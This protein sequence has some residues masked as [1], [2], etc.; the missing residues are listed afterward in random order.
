MAVKK[1]SRQG[2]PTQNG[3]RAE[4]KS[5][6]PEPVEKDGLETG[7][8]RRGCGAG[9]RAGRG[10]LYG[11]ISGRPDDCGG[12]RADG[13]GCPTAAALLTGFY[14]KPKEH[15]TQFGGGGWGKRLGRFTAVVP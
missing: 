15:T 6:G 10:I 8:R 11:I 5:V 3:P 13:H 2:T 12:E 4:Q 14:R 1:V 9:W 7:Q